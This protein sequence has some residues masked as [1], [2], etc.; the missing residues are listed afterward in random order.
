[1][2]QMKF[3]YIVLGALLVSGLAEA[4]T[5]YT[6]ADSTFRVITTA[7]PFLT[8]TPDARHA[9]LGDA[10]VATSPDANAA[11]WNPAKLAFID[12]AYGGSLSYTPWLGK[13]TNDM[14]ISYLSGFYKITREQTVA[15]GFKYF[16]L[17]DFFARSATNVDEGTFSPKEFSV[18]VTYSRMLTEELSLGLTGRY[19]H[20]NLLGSY[21]GSTITDT[22][23]G[24]SVAADIG[25]FYT[26]KLK[27]VKTNTLSLAASISNIGAKL[28]YSGDENK[29]FLPTNL[30]MGG[31]FTTEVDQFNSFTF[32]LDFN[33]LMVPSPPIY[34]T[35]N[36]QIQYDQDGNPIILKGKDPNRSLMSGMFGSFTDAP[37]GASEEFKEFIVNMGVEYWYNKIFAARAGY[38]LEAREK[39]NRKYL[40]VGIGFRKDKFGLDVAY[41]VPTNKREHPLAET[42]RF[43]VLYQIKS[44]TNEDTVID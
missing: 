3:S 28:T 8:I 17:G 37:D 26:K 7:V 20:S 29:D 5:S 21:N 11:Y 4:Q 40:T 31:A 9:G 12:K 13:I 39:G 36:G 42:V 22:K 15:L 24:N 34:E 27:G 35:V 18:D 14:W 33:K 44:K 23:P 2:K 43:T 38:F 30:R 10:G 19:I 41:I 25:I 1:M 16:D 6:G 32:I